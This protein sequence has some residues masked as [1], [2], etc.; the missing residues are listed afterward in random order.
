M[1]F[2]YF[3]KPPPITLNPA[4]CEPIPNPAPALAAFDTCGVYISSIAKVHEAVT[5]III[6]S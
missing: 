1:I 2:I 4:N 3:N 6:I 5:A